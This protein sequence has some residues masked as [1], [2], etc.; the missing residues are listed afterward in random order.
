MTNLEAMLIL[1]LNVA[2]LVTLLYGALTVLTHFRV[3]KFQVTN[4][5]VAHVEIEERVFEDG[6]SPTLFPQ[7]TVEYEWDGVK[8]CGKPFQ[9]YWPA[10]RARKEWDKTYGKA[11]TPGTPLEI[12]VDPSRPAQFTLQRLNRWEM[13]VAIMLFSAAAGIFAVEVVLWLR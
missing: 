12:Y 10:I 6:D 7:V 5:L 9:V 11:L 8:Y 4:G 13:L 2:G 1:I 3:R